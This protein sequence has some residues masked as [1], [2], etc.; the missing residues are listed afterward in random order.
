MPSNPF[1]ERFDTLVD[2][3][4]ERWHTPGISFAVVHGDDSWSKGYGIAQLPST[5]VDKDTLFYAASTT[6][7]HLCAAWALYIESK[8]NKGKPKDQQIS[9]STPLA[10]I[11]RDDFVLFDTIRTS[12]ITIEDAV[13]H[14]TGLPRHELAYGYEGVGTPRE[15][16]RNLR[17]LP[18]RTPLRSTFEY[19]NTMYVAASLALETFYGK[20]LAQIL[21]ESLW[22]PLGMRDT[23][24]GYDEAAKAVA[25]GAIVARPYIFS[26]S[27]GDTDEHSGELVEQRHISLREVSGTYRRR[28]IL[29]EA[30]T[31]S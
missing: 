27:P 19:C 18:L 4:L 28:A 25:S 2:Q 31:Q 5:P 24:A 29:H 12:Q 14:R 17:N 9:F 1:N 7:A 8:S 16:V 30:K 10:D 11:I 3:Q 21:R 22:T 26:K 23:F 15:L 6:K 20:S 13:S